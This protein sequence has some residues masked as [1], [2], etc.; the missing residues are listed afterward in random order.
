MLACDPGSG[1]AA[2]ELIVFAPSLGTLVCFIRSTNHEAIT[3]NAGDLRF[4]PSSCSLLRSSAPIGAAPSSSTNQQKG[5]S[6]LQPSEVR[7]IAHVAVMTFWCCMTVDCAVPNAALRWLRPRPV[8]VPR[9]CLR[10]GS[11]RRIDDQAW[12]R[13]L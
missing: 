8:L 11:E 2:A 5:R 9:R 4:G 6:A 13:A 3:A 7:C 10:S 1:S 12:L